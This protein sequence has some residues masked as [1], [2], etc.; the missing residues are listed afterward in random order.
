[1]RDPVSGGDL[2]D[3][4]KIARNLALSMFPG[5]GGHFSKYEVHDCAEME[6]RAKV[7]ALKTGIPGLIPGESPKIAFGM[8]IFV[9]IKEAP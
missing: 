6:H 1:M 3:A 2:K 7:E 4:K 5:G 8:A 9:G